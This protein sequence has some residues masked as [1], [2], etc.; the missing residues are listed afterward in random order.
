MKHKAQAIWFNYFHKV[1]VESLKRKN[2]RVKVNF[3]CGS[4]RWATELSFKD[5]PLN[6]ILSNNQT[7]TTEQVRKIVKNEIPWADLIASQPLKWKELN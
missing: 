2:E 3:R 6:F 1:K 4:K 5:S 7:Y